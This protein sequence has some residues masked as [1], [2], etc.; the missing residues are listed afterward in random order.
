MP[1]KPSRKN[2]K[3]LNFCQGSEISPNLVTLVPFTAIFLRLFPHPP[4]RISPRCLLFMSLNPP[5]PHPPVPPHRF[6][7]ESDN[8]KSNNISQESHFIFLRKRLRR[9]KQWRRQRRQW[10]QQQRDR[11]RRQQRRRKRRRQ[12]WRQRQRRRQRWC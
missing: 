10:R 4:L 1:N 9:W 3:H 11:R 2:Q 7:C 12:R 5:F 8:N 6:S